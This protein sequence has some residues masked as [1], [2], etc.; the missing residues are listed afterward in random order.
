MTDVQ[1]VA[2][3]RPR[4]LMTL[5]AGLAIAAVVLAAIGIHGLIATSVGERTR[6]MGIRLAL[7]ASLSQVLRTL[8]LPGIG[9]ACAGTLIG[10]A[11]ATA[12]GGFVRHFLWGVTA[13]DP[14]TYAAVAI[15]LVTVASIASVVPALRILRLDP[16]RTL[17][18]D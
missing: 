2:L 14:V 17:R 16:A 12:L 6:E 1:A 18:Q 5:L 4:F 8:T 15:I 10:G 9:L 11:A 7:G 13:T 3:A